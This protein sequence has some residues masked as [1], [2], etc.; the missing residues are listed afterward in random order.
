MILN[1][2]RRPRSPQAARLILSPRRFVSTRSSREPSVAR[3]QVATI[4]SDLLLTMNLNGNAQAEM[5]LLIEG[6]TAPLAASD[7]LL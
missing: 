1:P 5:S 7:F 2:D 6:V 4:D 3:P